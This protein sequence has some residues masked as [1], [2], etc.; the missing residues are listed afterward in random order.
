MHSDELHNVSHSPNIIRVIKSRRTRWAS[1]V[2]RILMAR[3]AYKILVGR[4]EGNRSLGG[5]GVQTGVWLKRSLENR[6]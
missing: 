2:A 4:S 6:V 3:N 1:H 5:L